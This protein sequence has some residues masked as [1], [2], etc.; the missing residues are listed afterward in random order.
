MKYKIIKLFLIVL[1][2]FYL[3]L[4]CSININCSSSNSFF[5]DYTLYS[6]LLNEFESSSSSSSLSDQSSLKNSSE[7]FNQNNIV[8][9][10]NLNKDTI[11]KYN[12]Y[13][14][15]PE[16]ERIR[17]KKLT[18]EMF[19]FG[20]DQYMAHAF[21]QDELDPIHCTGRGPDYLNRD[22]ININDA[23][24][25]YSLTLVDSLSSLAVLGNS[26]EFKKAARLVIESINFDKNN[27]VQVFEATIRVLGSLLSAHLIAIDKNQPFGDMT[28][29]NY[30]NELLDLAHDLGVRLLAAFDNMNLPY[31]RVNLRYGVP[32]NTFNHTCTSGAGMCY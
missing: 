6:Q 20:Y 19:E 14:H 30:N 3:L 15:F 8:N 2:E 13:L 10:F 1:I 11:E 29:D 21:P 9:H 16:S 12:E 22:N 25:D 32:N 28:I 23:L 18:K 24:G 7:S 5:L 31:P 27:T 17:L 4:P 26:S